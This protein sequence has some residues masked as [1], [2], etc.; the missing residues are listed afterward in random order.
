MLGIGIS[1]HE[2]W[3]IVTE[4]PCIGFL[5]PTLS[6][7]SLIDGLQMSRHGSSWRTS[8]YEFLY[9]LPYATYKAVRG[10]GQTPG[11]VPHAL[12]CGTKC[13]VLL[14]DAHS[15]SVG[16]LGKKESFFLRILLPREQDMRLSRNMSVILRA[17]E[18]TVS[19]F[20]R[21]F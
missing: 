11:R 3:G 14:L 6:I 18:P 8:Q 9:G 5:F 12:A 17:G 15:R 10:R 19:K 16:S 1:Y 2:V 7:E 21:K 20:L 4:P 13:C